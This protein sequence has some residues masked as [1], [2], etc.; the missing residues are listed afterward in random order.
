MG[1]MKVTINL[2]ELCKSAAAG[3]AEPIHSEDFIFR[4]LLKPEIAVTEYFRNGRESAE[5]LATILRDLMPSRPL[6]MLEFASGYGCVTRHLHNTVPHVDV[7]CCDIHEAAV[8]F[9][10]EQ[11]GVKAVIS[12]TIPETFDLGHTFDVVFALSFFSHT[13][14]RRWARWLRRLLDHVSSG[15]ILIFTTH[16]AASAKVIAEGL[17]TS[18]HPVNG[19]WFQGFS[20]QGDL[21]VQDYGTTVTLEEYVKRQIAVIPSAALERFQEFYW[22]GHQDLYVVRKF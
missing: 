21:D 15:G 9:L 11:I 5:K 13:P 3:V 12:N 10:R 1:G 7:T 6:S 16:G 19:F 4:F 8:A 20:E 22:W 18:V 14:E 17:R 2:T